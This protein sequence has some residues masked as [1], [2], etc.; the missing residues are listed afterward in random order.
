MNPVL[1]FQASELAL[2]DPSGERRKYFDR[3][4]RD[5]FQPG[6]I[7]QVRFKDRNAEPFAG[8]LINIRR[9]GIDTGFLLRG[10][11]TNLGVEMWYKAYSPMI[12]SVQLLQ[13]S[14]KRA[15]R[16]KLYYMRYVYTTYILS[17]PCV[18]SHFVQIDDI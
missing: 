12:E 5:S 11:L 14:P 16:A 10:N 17:L 8:V 13:R 4:S 9:R 2:L 18:G 7:L 3:R 15:R 6:D 1:K